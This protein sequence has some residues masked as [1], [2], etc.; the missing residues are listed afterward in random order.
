[1]KKTSMLVAL[2]IGT[3]AAFAQDLTSS[4]GEKYLPEAGDW[5][6]SI[7]ATPFLTYVG[8]ML[9]N[10]PNPS[11]TWGF[12]TNNQTIVG[13]KFIDATSAY[14][15]ILRIGYTNETTTEQ[16]AEANTTV[17]YPNAQPTVNDKMI[18]QNFALALGAGKEWR[19][20]TTRLQGYYGA[21]VMLGMNSG[22]TSYK[23]GNALSTSSTAPVVVANSYNFGSN[24][25]TLPT[26]YQGDAARVLNANNGF[27]LSF[28]VRGFIGAEYFIIPKISIGG[29]FGWGLGFTATGKSDSKVEGIG[30]TTPTVNSFSTKTGG[31]FNFWADT[32][33]NN[34]LWGLAGQ[35]KLT[36][37]F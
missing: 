4:K 30:G 33:N 15:G 17:T 13:K 34:P 9:G 22:A 11:P 16:S 21:D 12:I 31:A 2:A 8:Q 14:R 6:I 35:L 24:I 3:S 37:H 29:E 27:A 10:G 18:V 20:G 23:Y 26:P 28:G 7:N 19:K 5:A 36:M 1:M 32:D 25:T